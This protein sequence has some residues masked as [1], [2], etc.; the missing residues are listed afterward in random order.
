MKK[1]DCHRALKLTKKLVYGGWVVMLLCMYLGTSVE[2]FRN[3]AI[4]PIVGAFLVSVAGL[5]MGLRAIKCPH[6]GKSLTSGAK[7]PKELP[8]ICPYCREWL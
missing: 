6:C 8:E 3:I 7:L 4:F 1:M 2:N 5:F